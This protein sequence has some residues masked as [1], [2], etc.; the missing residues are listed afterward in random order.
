MNTICDICG[1]EITLKEQIVFRKYIPRP[2]Y[3]YKLIDKYDVC[4]KCFKNVLMEIKRG[5][6]ESKLYKR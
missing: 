2:F 4:D 1:K 5:N 3:N 6:N